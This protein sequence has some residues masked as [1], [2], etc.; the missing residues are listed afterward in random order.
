MSDVSEFSKKNDMRQRILDA[1]A[2]LLAEHGYK[3]TTLRG[4]AEAAGLKAASI[5]YHFPSK[6]QITVEV[7]NE[8]VRHV[9]NAVAESGFKLPEHASGQEILEA[10]IRAHF[11]TLNEHSA[12]TRASIKCFSNIP[13]EIRT[14]TIE[15]R[16]HFDKVWQDI[17]G[18]VQKRGVIS[19][20]KDIKS[21]HLIILGTLNWTLEWQGASAVEQKS[22]VKTLRTAILS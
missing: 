6:E 20:E 14:Q 5:Y 1:A 18:K 22:P 8:G 13:Q 16:R 15:I 2:V 3:A 11:T 4:I 21:L 12:Y 9:S 17:L 10:A 19:S 7:L